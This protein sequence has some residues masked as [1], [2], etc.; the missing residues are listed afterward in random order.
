MII[1][2]ELERLKIINDWKKKIRAYDAYGYYFSNNFDALIKF[3]K[4]EDPVSE[5][6]IISFFF[7]YIRTLELKPID[8]SIFDT[9]GLQFLKKMKKLLQADDMLETIRLLQKI[10]YKVKNYRA[11][12]SYQEFFKEM[13][14]SGEIQTNLSVRNFTKNVR[15]LGQRSFCGPIYLFNK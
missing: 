14:L 1:E 13:K 9:L 5:N 12:L 8:D 6:S 3:L 10:F 2:V 4:L 11:L 7:Q 15:M